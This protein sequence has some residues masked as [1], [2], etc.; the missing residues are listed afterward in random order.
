MLVQKVLVH[1]NE[2]KRL[3]VQFIFNGAFEQSVTKYNDEQV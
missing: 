1:K 2:D 3:D